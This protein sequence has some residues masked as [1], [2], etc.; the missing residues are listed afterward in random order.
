[1]T[2]PRERSTNWVNRFVSLGII[3]TCAGAFLYAVDEILRV[4]RVGGGVAAQLI[5]AAVCVFIL[6]K[7]RKRKQWA[8]RLFIM[9]F[10][11]LSIPFVPAIVA[12]PQGG[13]IYSSNSFL[14]SLQRVANL[15]YLL[16][17]IVF[18]AYLFKPSTRALFSPAPPKM[19]QRILLGLG[20]CMSFAAGSVGLWGAQKVGEYVRLEGDDVRLTK[21]GE[22]WL[23]PESEEGRAAAEKLLKID[24]PKWG[25]VDDVIDGQ[26]FD[27]VTLYHFTLGASVALFISESDQRLPVEHMLS[28]L[29]EQREAWLKQSPTRTL[30]RLHEDERRWSALSPTV[31]GPESFSTSGGSLD[32]QRVEFRAWEDGH[33]E[34]VQIATQKDGRPVTILVY[35]ETLDTQAVQDF[36]DQFLSSAN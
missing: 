19:Y 24:V 11:L 15:G 25:L 21:K 20:A 9:L 22:A 17:E 4:G 31:T 14:A 13:V 7:I 26:G 18:V 8:R 35:G 30:R 36:L 23:A 33:Q 34:G 2:G 16:F 10:V 32:A 29:D 1:M 12:S 27:V 3:L 6:L 5:I 28:L